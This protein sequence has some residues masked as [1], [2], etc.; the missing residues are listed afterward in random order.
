MACRSLHDGESDLAFAL[1]WPRNVAIRWC[2]TTA[3]KGFK[4][5]PQGASELDPAGKKAIK[6]GAP[7]SGE[8]VMLSLKAIFSDTTME[9]QENKRVLAYHFIHTIHE[10]IYWVCG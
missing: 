4:R 5:T 2:R 3:S 9:S 1:G 8:E 10:R 6:N 7:L